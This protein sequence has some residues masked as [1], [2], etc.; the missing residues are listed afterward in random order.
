MP[1]VKSGVRIT[2]ILFRIVAFWE[3]WGLQS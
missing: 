3:C 2:R 1:F